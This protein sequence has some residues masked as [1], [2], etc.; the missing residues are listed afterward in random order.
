MKSHPTL[1]S[2]AD[3]CG[4][5]HVTVW[6]ALRRH[7]NVHPRTAE[8]IISHAGDVGYSVEMDGRISSVT[9]Q[10]RNRRKI[11]SPTILVPYNNET[12]A[13][14]LFWDYVAGI[15]E[16]STLSESR[17]LLAGFEGAAMEL[18]RIRSHI[19][20]GAQGV[21]D[22]GLQ[23]D[24]LDWLANKRVPMVTLLTGHRPNP[25]VKASITADHIHGFLDAWHHLRENGHTRIGFVGIQDSPHSAVRLRECLAAGHLISDSVDVYATIWIPDVHSGNVI[26]ESLES[27]LG[28]WSARAWPTAF[29]CTNDVAASRVITVLSERGIAIPSDVSVVGFDNSPVSLVTS[30]RIT[31]IANPRKQIGAAMLHM[32]ENIIADLPGSR[33]ASQTIPMHLVK[34][35]SVSSR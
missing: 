29:F 1:H 9:R 15:T 18:S 4:V 24:T 6:R 19:E 12:E 30:P 8:R 22:F 34:R 25:H 14:N 5:S 28:P 3:Q 23:P 10:R 2:I 32:L 33:A 20:E 11:T 27:D 16:A 17:V 26:W 21:L 7:P 13:D 35:E 31:T